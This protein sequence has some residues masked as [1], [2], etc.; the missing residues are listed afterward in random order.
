MAT[1]RRRASQ[2]SRFSTQKVS[3]PPHT[4]GERGS[5]HGAG[6][7][8][9]RTGIPERAQHGC[10]TADTG[11]AIC[12]T[13]GVKEVPSYSFL[14]LPNERWLGLGTAAVRPVRTSPPHRARGVVA[15]VGQSLPYVGSRRWCRGWLTRPSAVDPSPRTRERAPPHFLPRTSLLPARHVQISR[16]AHPRFP[17]VAAELAH[18][19]FPK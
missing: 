13:S 4:R 5:C 19:L 6:C 14:P 12:C 11:V 7:I 2:L 8:F 3:I 17:L 18:W 9:Q 16:S 1:P 15:T 10:R